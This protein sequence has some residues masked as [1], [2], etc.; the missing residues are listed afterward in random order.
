M[1]YLNKYVDIGELKAET[2]LS[3]LNLKE[4]FNV[5]MESTFQRNYAEDVASIDNDGFINTIRLARTGIF[6][7]LPE[8]L[9][10]KENQLN[11]EN[12]RNYDFKRTYQELQKKKNEILAFFQPFD[13]QYFKLTLEFE[14]L[15]NGFTERGNDILLN[16]FEYETEV[17]TDNYYVSKITKILPFAG[18]IKGNLHLVIDILKNVL[19]VEKI[20]MVEIEPFHTRFMIHKEGLSKEEFDAMDKEV[21][22]FFTFFKDTFLPVERKYDFRIK[23]FKQTFTLGEL[24]LLDYNTNL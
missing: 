9:F 21:A 3:I 8:G 22:I 10:F 7:L 1:K 18:Q 16:A 14:Q 19:S 11:A 23:D 5:Q 13:T 20:D 17:K 6:K 4:D 2:L 15:L 12:K 24:L